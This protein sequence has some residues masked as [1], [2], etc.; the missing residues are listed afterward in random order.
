ME[1]CF[2]IITLRNSGPA[3]TGPAG[4]V[5]IPLIILIVYTKLINKEVFLLNSDFTIL[6]C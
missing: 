5:P 6:F 1:F 4:P 3:K 2:Y